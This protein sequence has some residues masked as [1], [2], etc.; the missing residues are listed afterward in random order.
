MQVQL[1]VSRVGCTAVYV[2]GLMVEGESCFQGLWGRVGAHGFRCWGL[3]LQD[4]D[5]GPWLLPSSLEDLLIFILRVYL[6]VSCG[7]LTGINGI[8]LFG[9]MS[10]LKATG[11]CVVLRGVFGSADLQSRVHKTK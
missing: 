10:C 1:G 9:L 6:Q 4:S 5:C 7:V 8:V 11:A 2:L 3:S